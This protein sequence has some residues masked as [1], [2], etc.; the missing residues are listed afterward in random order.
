MSFPMED[1]ARVME[2]A[3]ME[4]N[5]VYFISKTMQTKL[6]LLCLGIRTAFK[7]DKYEEPLVWEQYIK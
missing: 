1:R 2:Y 5:E 4:G 6:K 3:M 7:M